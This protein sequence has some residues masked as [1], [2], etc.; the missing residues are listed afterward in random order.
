MI[1]YTQMY[2]AV[3]KLIYTRRIIN[4]SMGNPQ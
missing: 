4:K 3:S 2:V 1:T